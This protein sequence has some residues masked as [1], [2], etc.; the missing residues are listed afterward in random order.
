MK[1]KIILDGQDYVSDIGTE[2]S[3]SELS[4]QFY[5][6][7]NDF[8]MAR[9][10]LVTGEFLVLNKSAMNRAVFIFSD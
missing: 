8:N 7:V 9:Y 6:Q 1:I 10:L 2:K 3:A 4:K 5:D